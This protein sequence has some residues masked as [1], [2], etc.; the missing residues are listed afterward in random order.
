MDCL[1]TSRLKNGLY[2]TFAPTSV[3]SEYFLDGTAEAFKEKM[4]VDLML[5]ALQCIGDSAPFMAGIEKRDK[6]GQV[7]VAEHHIVDSFR[8]DAAVGAGKLYLAHFL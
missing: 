2:V 3:R 1:L 7:E 5:H 6:I 4:R 8:L